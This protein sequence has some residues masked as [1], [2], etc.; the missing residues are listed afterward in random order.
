MSATSSSNWAAMRNTKVETEA[1]DSHQRSI[2][3]TAAL[4][5]AER[6]RKVLSLHDPT[7]PRL[8]VGVTAA[9][10]ALGI[11][12]GLA[13]QLCRDYLA[14]RDG[15]PCRRFGP[16]RVLIP[17]KALAELADLGSNDHDQHAS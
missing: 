8:F 12:R 15:I 4:D 3:R 11:S 1:R 9:A 13:Y 10:Q 16:R 5:Y 17:L 7:V 14:G 6:G 2:P